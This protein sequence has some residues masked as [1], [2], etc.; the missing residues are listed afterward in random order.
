[1]DFKSKAN[2]QHRN[3]YASCRNHTTRLT[4]D[5]NPLVPPAASIRNPPSGTSPTQT[6]VSESRT[7]GIISDDTKVRLTLVA[8]SPDL[9]QR[10]V[11][12]A[13]VYFGRETRCEFAPYGSQSQHSWHARSALPPNPT[14]PGLSQSSYPMRQA[15]RPM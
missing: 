13:K 7:V 1:M 10:P 15:A 12:P 8:P 4:H 6:G 14:R 11:P 5:L 3:R 2:H 9:V